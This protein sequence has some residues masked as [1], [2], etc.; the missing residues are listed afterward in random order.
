[1]RRLRHKEEPEILGK[2]V[3]GL[4]D[5]VISCWLSEMAMPDGQVMGERSGSVMPN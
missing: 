2:S 5:T 4:L 3:C 1:M